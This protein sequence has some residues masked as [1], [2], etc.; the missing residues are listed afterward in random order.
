MRVARQAASGLLA[1]HMCRALMW[2]EWH[3]F[4]CVESSEDCRNGKEFSMSFSRIFGPTV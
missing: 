2:P 4:S 3:I 1:G